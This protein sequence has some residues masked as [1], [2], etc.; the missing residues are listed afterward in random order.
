MTIT[1]R[2]PVFVVRAGGAT[3]TG[4]HRAHNEDSYLVASPVFVVAD[5]MGGH[6]RGLAASSAVVAA[7]EE[8]A[9]ADWVSSD[10][11]HAAVVAA[12]ES[13]DA[14]AEHGNHP[15]STLAGVALTHQAGRP[16]WLAFNIG[17][18]RVYLLRGEAL[19]QVSVD[20]SRVQELLESG[21]PASRITV[22]RNIITR[23]IGGGGDG[24][25]VLD[26]WLVP[27]MAGDRVLVCSD[28]L[29]GEVTDLLMLATLVEQRDPQ[30]GAR[31]LVAAALAAG[32][33]DNVTAVVIDAL[34]VRAAEEGC[35][36]DADTLG[37]EAWVSTTSDDT[38]PMGH[39]WEQR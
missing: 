29:S 39:G 17:D 4:L 22:G 1:E 3:D 9:R 34:D 14:M 25:P 23:A 28:G 13:V 30:S 2:R 24:V 32:G 38:I 7:F 8:L 26:Q 37:D 11:L 33:R 19:E 15:G 27:A 31:A 21:T 10:A 6:T 20:H 16:Y 12:S 5:G 35:A 18:S 36:D